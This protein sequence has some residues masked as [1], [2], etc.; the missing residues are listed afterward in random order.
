M[1]Y[2]ERV[3]PSRRPSIVPL[4]DELGGDRKSA[5]A[6]GFVIKKLWSLEE[7]LSHDRQQ[8]SAIAGNVGQSGGKMAPGGVAGMCCA[9][10]GGGAL[11]LK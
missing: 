2:R 5:K 11:G 10:V 8:W 4:A 7:H 1:P 6:R 9:R 3:R